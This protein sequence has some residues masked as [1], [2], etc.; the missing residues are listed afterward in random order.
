[1]NDDRKGTAG[2]GGPDVERELGR[3][4]VIPVPPG[5]GQ[6]VLGRAMEVRAQAALTPRL[7]ALA[8]A[9]SIVILAVLAADPVF[10]RREA[11]RITAVVDG[12]AAPVPATSRLPELAEA[13]DG[14]DGDWS[15]MNRLQALAASAAR[16]EARHD[17]ISARERL[18]G[19][20]S[21]ETPEDL[22]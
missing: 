19:W 17:L 3:L 5:L 9:C 16:M 12:Q 14:Q 1:M 2:E 10:S 11:S 22:N 13:L 15:R 18:K 6:R 8:A 21:Y 4:A 20:L 7:R